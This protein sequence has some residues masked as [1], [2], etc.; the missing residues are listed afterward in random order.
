MYIEVGRRRR[1]TPDLTVSRYCVQVIRHH[2][3]LKQPHAGGSKTAKS[4]TWGIDDPCK[5]RNSSKR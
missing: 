3:N 5:S 2:R 1:F 4:V